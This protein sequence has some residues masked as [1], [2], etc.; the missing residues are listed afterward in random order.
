MHTTTCVC[1]SISAGHNFYYI[2]KAWMQSHPPTHSQLTK[3]INMQPP[4]PPR[5]PAF[6][7]SLQTKV[8]HIFL[9][10]NEAIHTFTTRDKKASSLFQFLFTI[11][12]SPPSWSNRKGDLFPK[13][14]V[15][16][17]SC[18]CIHVRRRRG[19]HISSRRSRSSDFWAF[20]HMGVSTFVQSSSSLCNKTWHIMLGS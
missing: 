15:C 18:V 4:P 8:V 2:K 6:L 19:S 5:S 13:L 12:Q 3:Q 11:L 17:Y 10:N 1:S 7:K 9:P 16:L 20:W 14:I